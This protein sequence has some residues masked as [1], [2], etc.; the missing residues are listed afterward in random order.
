MTAESRH[1][2]ESGGQSARRDGGGGERRV[3]SLHAPRP[4]CA[5]VLHLLSDLSRRKLYGGRTKYVWSTRVT[6]FGNRVVA[7]AFMLRI[8][9]IRILLHLGV[10]RAHNNTTRDWLTLTVHEYRPSASVGG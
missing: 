10:Q 9:V 7:L 8:W 2:P 5:H 6:L 4:H 1:F 3:R